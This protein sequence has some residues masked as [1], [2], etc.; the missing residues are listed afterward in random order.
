MYRALSNFVEN[1]I[2]YTNCPSTITIHAE[3]IEGHICLRIID[4]GIGIPAEAIPHVWDRFY[5][6]DRSRKEAED[7]PGLGMSIA[8]AILKAHGCTYGIQSQLGKGTTVW[9]SFSPR[10]DE[11]LTG[12]KED[13]SK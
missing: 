4:R 2:K 13:R 9:I 3:P 7:S 6:V 5:K 8:K 12:K 11:S 10:L 1:A